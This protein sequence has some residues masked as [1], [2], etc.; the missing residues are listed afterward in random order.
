MALAVALIGIPFVLV[1]QF[2][3]GANPQWAGRYLLVSGFL[4][5]TFGWA[6]LATRHP[7]LRGA[8]ALLAVVVTIGGVAWLQVRSHDVERAFA[9]LESRPEPVTVSSLYFFAR[10]GGATYGDHRWLTLS[11]G[12]GGGA[13]DAARVLTAAGIDEFASVQP[14][15]TRPLRFP[16][17]TPAGTSDLRLFDGV[18]LTVKSWR[19]LP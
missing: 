10:E 11:P 16:G 13:A 2:T 12:P 6:A 3:G 8:F 9:A 17:F 7:V 4:L 18:D 1:T 5:A 14:T 15:A 19:K